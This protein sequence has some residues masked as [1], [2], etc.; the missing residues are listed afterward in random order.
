MT[1]FIYICKLR[2]IESDIQQTVYRVDQ[3]T[4]ATKEEVEKFIQRLDAWKA[5]MPMDARKANQPI[6]SVDRKVPA[7]ESRCVDGYDNYVSLSIMCVDNN[8]FNH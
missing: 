5:N 2:I 4:P 1:G 7:L 8:W 3:A 6:E